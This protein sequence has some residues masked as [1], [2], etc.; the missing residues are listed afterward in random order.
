MGGGFGVGSIIVA[1]Q[2]Q[3]YRTLGFVPPGA[4][5]A[6]LGLSWAVWT[7]SLGGPCFLV[8]F[9][10][11]LIAIPLWARSL[12][13]IPW[14][15]RV[16]GLALLSLVIVIASSGLGG[17]L[18]WLHRVGSLNWHGQL[19]VL[20]LSGVVCAVITMV[21]W[22]RE[23]VELV[24]EAILCPVYRVRAR[25]PGLTTFPER[26][27]VIVIANHAAWFD[28]LWLG[29][30][31]PRPLTPLMTSR[32]FDMRVLHWL[33][34]HV[35]K[36]IRVPES[37]FRREAPELN[38]AIKILDQGDCLLI[39]PEGG[40]K[41]K[42][43][44]VLHPFGQGVWRILEQRP[45]TPVVP[46]WIEGNWGSSTSY[47]NGPPFKGKPLDWWRPINIGVGDAVRLSGELLKDQRETRQHLMEACLA[48]RDHVGV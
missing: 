19:V 20:S 48:A 40:M 17:L 4:F 9:M 16:R 37:T 32:Y 2:R 27:G 33:M 13:E 29:K 15:N 46:C 5:G 10:A 8:G 14:S 24:F 43:E 36:A 34:T 42:P 23:L 21:W 44:Q 6:A 12:F 1:L 41:R 39:F 25:G 7:T 18:A 31:M 30:I 26:G 28:P 35:V 45:Q 22:L 47:C 3:G 11:A 38:E